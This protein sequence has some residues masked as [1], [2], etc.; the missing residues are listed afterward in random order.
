MRQR[1][2]NLLQATTA[3]I[4]ILVDKKIQH[5]KAGDRVLKEY[6]RSINKLELI[7]EADRLEEH[8]LDKGNLTFTIKPPLI[9]NIIEATS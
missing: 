2:E 7:G 3:T 8:L 1:V 4:S 5:F 6:L 9:E